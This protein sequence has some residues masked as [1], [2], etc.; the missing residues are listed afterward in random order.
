VHNVE[1]K[2]GDCGA[3]MVL[4]TTNK[5]TYRN[6]D[7]RPFYG[8]SRWPECQGT[9]GAHPDGRPMGIPGDA[10]TKKARHEAHLAFEAL[11]QQRGWVGG[12][13]QKRGAYTWLGRKLGI[14]EQQIETECHIGRFD[15]A[16]CKR[17]VAI[18]EA[19]MLRP[20]RAEVAVTNCDKTGL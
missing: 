9:H 18:C 6:G 16:T 19:A 12:K 8:C 7:P 3:P 20:K 10:A 1:V 17:V 4:R 2:C 15:I 5:Y 13:H 14:I 11:C